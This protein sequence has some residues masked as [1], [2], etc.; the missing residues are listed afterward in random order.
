[1]SSFEASRPTDR[2]IKEKG[3]MKRAFVKRNPKSRR[4][5]GI[6]VSPLLSRKNSEASREATEINIE[7]SEHRRKNRNKPRKKKKKKKRNKSDRTFLLK[8]C[9]QTLLSAKTLVLFDHP[10]PHT[11]LFFRWYFIRLHNTRTVSQVNCLFHEFH[12]GPG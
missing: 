5:G 7:R 2:V 3:I 8:F 1:M 11:L 4:G 9:Q 12:A 10:P 6:T